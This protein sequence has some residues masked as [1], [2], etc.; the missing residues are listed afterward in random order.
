MV[1]LDRN[2]VLEYATFKVPY[3]ELNMEFRRGHKARESFRDFKSKLEQLDAA[4]KDAV[5]K[6]RQFIK[7]MQSRIQFL[8]NELMG[9]IALC[10]PNGVPAYKELL[11]EHRWQALADLFR[12][13]VF[14]LY[15]LPR[16]SAFA[17][18]LQCGL[19]AYKTP[20]CSPGGVERCPTCQPC[21]FA[22]AEG[23]PYAHTVNSRLICSYSGE[24]L[25]EENHPMM[26][27]DGRVYGEKAI[28]EL[29]IDSNTVHYVFE[30][31]LL[32]YNGELVHGYRA[33]II[34][35]DLK[36]QASK[37]FI[38]RVHKGNEAWT[39]NPNYAVLIDTRDRLI[40][41]LGYIV[42]ENIELHRGRIIHNLLKNYMERY[43]EAKQSCPCSA[44]GDKAVAAMVLTC[45]EKAIRFSYRGSTRPLS[46]KQPITRSPNEVWKSVIKKHPTEGK[47]LGH[48]KV[49]TAYKAL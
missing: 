20:H 25:N 2:A 17:I 10:A 13:E 23:L 27:P 14:A 35:W 12:E 6:Q 22:L 3:E 31:A 5:K 11:S 29:Q 7:N 24:A 18:C 30:N 34:G 38:E 8:R 42:Q 37:D 9:L 39:N 4:K 32:M 48:E 19:S 45:G 28:R 16:Q 44:E 40:P 15:Q 49:A 33:V 36:A 41:Q 21:A 43:D 47:T 26:M 46:P 1:K